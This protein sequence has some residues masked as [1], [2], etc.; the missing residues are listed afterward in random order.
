M[1]RL[2]LKRFTLLLAAC[3]ILQGCGEEQRAST[4]R[5]PVRLAALQAGSL[6]NIS[7]PG[8]A[9][10]A[11]T[12]WSVRGGRSGKEAIAAVVRPL[13]PDCE[14]FVQVVAERGTGARELARRRSLARR[15]KL[16]P[17][18]MRRRVGADGD[19]V[20]AAIFNSP[21]G[22]VFGGGAT[23]HGATAVLMLSTPAGRRPGVYVVAQG[24]TDGYACREGDTA[25]ARELSVNVL[26]HIGDSI[27]YG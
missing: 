8:V 1:Q 27:R 18:P 14:V 3:L 10:D 21:E 23:G 15:G 22:L 26:T 6:T 19:V 24:G 2:D 25:R 13:H 17:L 5:S 12:G 20:S 7:G 11:P 4:A 16:A 9:F